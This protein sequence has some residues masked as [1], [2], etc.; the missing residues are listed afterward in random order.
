[1]PTQS[2]D[3]VVVRVRNEAGGGAGVLRDLLKSLPASTAVVNDV[4][5]MGRV[6]LRLPPG[7]DV[8]KVVDDLKANPGVI[9]AEPVF[10][11]YGSG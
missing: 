1:M 9:Y 7:T 10:L 4:D 5:G 11:D 2:A 8:A 6:V 3:R